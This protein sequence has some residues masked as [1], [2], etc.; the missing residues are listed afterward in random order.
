MCVFFFF[1]FAFY[2]LIFSDIVSI[3]LESESLNPKAPLEDDETSASRRTCQGKNARSVF[4]PKPILLFF[5]F[6]IPYL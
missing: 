2:F 6:L 4:R 5:F 3:A 1:F